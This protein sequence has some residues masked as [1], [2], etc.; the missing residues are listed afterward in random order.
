[1]AKHPPA[2]AGDTGFNP[3]SGNPAHAS[4]Q[5]SPS[6]QLLRPSAAATEV[7]EPGAH[8]LQQEESPQ[9]EAHTMQ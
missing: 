8:D 6:P 4:E 3:W 2:N 1:M 7:H 5:L 9:E